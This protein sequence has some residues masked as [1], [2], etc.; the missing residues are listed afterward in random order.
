MDDFLL[1]VKEF[2]FLSVIGKRVKRSLEE[3]YLMGI[4]QNEVDQRL[5]HCRAIFL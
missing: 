4:G 2:G 5:T 3:C 1:G